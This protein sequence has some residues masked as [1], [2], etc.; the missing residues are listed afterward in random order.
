MKITITLTEL[1]NLVCSVYGL[2]ADTT[3]SVENTTVNVLPEHLDYCVLKMAFNNAR[4]V[5]VSG[6]ILPE[7]KISAIKLVRELVSNTGR[8]CGLPQAKYAVE[9]W[10][11]FCNYVKAHGYPPMALEDP[12][13][14]WKI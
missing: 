12:D 11:N 10:K 6:S 13:Y 9:D 8:S 1:H 7:S 2:P 4:L 14:G 5:T 3:V